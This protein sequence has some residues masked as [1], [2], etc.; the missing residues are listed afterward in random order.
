MRIN[1]TTS[2]NI[3]LVQQNE[4][5]SKK[6]L[7]LEITY[8]DL[9]TKIYKK[10]NTIK[11]RSS[12]SVDFLIDNKI[13]SPNHIRKSIFG[14]FSKNPM[15]KDSSILTSSLLEQPPNLLS[16]LFFFLKLKKLKEKNNNITFADQN[17]NNSISK[18]NNKNLAFTKKLK[19]DASLNF[20]CSESFNNKTISSNES[21]KEVDDKLL[22]LFRNNVYDKINLEKTEEENKL[23][24]FEIFYDLRNKSYFLEKKFGSK[25]KG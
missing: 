2:K 12:I 21:D 22:E 3:L 4:E 24:P 25:K 6:Y 9:K 8:N 14:N 5:L 11:K 16:Y 7:L 19:S 23:L 13:I 15:E 1:E 10:R 20:T 17:L 18:I